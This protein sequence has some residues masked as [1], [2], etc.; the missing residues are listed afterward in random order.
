M[1][2]ASRTTDTWSMINYLL[3]DRDKVFRNHAL[4]QIEGEGWNPPDWVN[5]SKLVHNFNVIPETYWIAK[6]DLTTC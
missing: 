1:P 2:H 4:E 5:L 3:E 6:K